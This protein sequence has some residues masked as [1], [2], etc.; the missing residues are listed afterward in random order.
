LDRL[1]RDQTLGLGDDLVGA[2]VI[3]RALNHYDVVLEIRD[4]SAVAASDQPEAASQILA[5]DG[6]R[7][8]A[9]AARPSRGAALT[10]SIAACELGS[11]LALRVATLRATR[12]TLTAAGSAAPRR[13][14]HVHWQVDL[15]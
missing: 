1:A 10:F 15:H 9:S 13:R 7:C 12:S 2:H 4:D 6:C 5:L 11:T 8:A 3:R 14:R